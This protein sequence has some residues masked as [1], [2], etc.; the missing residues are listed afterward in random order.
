MKNI[1]VILIFSLFIVSCSNNGEVPNADKIR[2]YKHQIKELQQKITE[3]EAEIA[4]G[5]YT[6]LRVPV[7]VEAVELQPFSHSFTAAGELESVAEAYISPEV[8]GQIVAI[9]VAE[10]QRVKE[11]QVLA[12][13]NTVIVEKN[14]AEIKSQINLAKIVYEKQSKLWE[15]NIGSELEY[16]QAKN[17]YE[18]LL[19]TL[20]TLQAQLDLAVIESPINGIVEE[21]F[22]KQGEL[23]SPGM[24][25]MQI[26]DLEDLI[27][28][29][30]LSEAYL[31]VVK[32]GD[33]VDITFPSY[34]DVVFHEKIWRT[35]NIINKANRTFIVEVKI[36]NKDGLLK[37][38]MLANITINDYSV[39]DAIV[40]PS[41]LIREDMEG[42][43]IFVSEKENDR[44]IAVK[45]YI[46][47]GKS[48][49]DMTEVIDGL[50]AGDVIITDGYS[51][52]SKGAVIT[53]MD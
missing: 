9:E 53:I 41:I 7:R 30:K 17:N 38:N 25:L 52:V 29:V 28:S 36:N 11:G 18:S 14:I 33:F 37:P 3:V 39:D 24:Q 12:R 4:K 1:F 46:K 5:D 16:L 34:P 22:S 31:P 44:D 8:S 26:V 49:K 27:V 15:R 21:I 19:R 48:S 47:T 23:A 35:G 42:S 40:L 10:G 45:K 13:L 43:F 50:S 2:D 6:G 51:N 20:E 32:K